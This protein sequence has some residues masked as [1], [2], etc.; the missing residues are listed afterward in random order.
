LGKVLLAFIDVFNIK[1]YESIKSTIEKIQEESSLN[2][3]Q[4]LFEY[5]CLKIF[6]VDFAVH[7]A[8]G[9]TNKKSEILD[10]FYEGIE[11]WCNENALRFPYM[12]NE[13]KLRLLDYTLSLK[14]EADIVKDL[15][16]GWPVGKVFA[17]YCKI[18]KDPAKTKIA[19]IGG[20]VFSGFLLAVIKSV[21]S[22]QII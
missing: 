15:G 1:N 17:K 5:C 19:M 18:E 9:K 3:D 16:P 22:F 2:I 12:Y 13:I 7:Q 21:D 14:D 20:V 4:I 6:T 10:S 8:L 11:E